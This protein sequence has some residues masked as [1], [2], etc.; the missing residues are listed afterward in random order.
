[1][2]LDLN[3]SF[4]LKF[5]NKPVH[6]LAVKVCNPADFGVLDSRHPFFRPS[7]EHTENPC[8]SR[9]PVNATIPLRMSRG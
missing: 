5:M 9:L 3:I 7:F 1:M 8:F 4:S 6:L 2:A